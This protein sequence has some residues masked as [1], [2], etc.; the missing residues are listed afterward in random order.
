MRAGKH[1]EASGRRA[2]WCHAVSMQPV[3][4]QAFQLYKKALFLV[5]FDEAPDENPLL[6]PIEQQGFFL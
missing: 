4:T 5:E 6:D 3:G 2:I 1:E